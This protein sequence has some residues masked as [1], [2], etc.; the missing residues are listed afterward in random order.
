MN[1]LWAWGDLEG[2]PWTVPNAFFM[3]M[4]IA[5]AICLGVAFALWMLAS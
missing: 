4:T 3:G 1:V 2:S 5:G